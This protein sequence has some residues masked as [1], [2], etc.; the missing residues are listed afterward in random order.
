MPNWRGPLPRMR[1]RPLRATR[2]S[3][4]ARV[5]QMTSS[6][7]VYLQV[8]ANGDGMRTHVSLESPA[9]VK[10]AAPISDSAWCFAAAA[11]GEQ[12]HAG[13]SHLGGG[14]P[15]PRTAARTRDRMPSQPTTRSAVKEAPFSNTSVAGRAAAVEAADSPQSKDTA[16]GWRR[17]GRAGET[18]RVCMHGHAYAHGHL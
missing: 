11:C 17:A 10:R 9:H 8:R 5:T 13:I 2:S 6:V 4:R 16:Q 18:H 3:L 1:L 14:S 7:P 15:A 12:T